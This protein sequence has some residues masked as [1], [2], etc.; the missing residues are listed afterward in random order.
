MYA[1]LHK[2]RKE[3]EKIS[4]YVLLVHKHRNN[5]IEPNNSRSSYVDWPLLKILETKQRYARCP[6]EKGCK[7]E[8]NTRELLSKAKAR[9]YRTG[10]GG[11]KCRDYDTTQTELRRPKAM[12]LTRQYRIDHRIGQKHH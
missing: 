5:K 2:Q 10:L 1:A 11:V 6:P 9:V 7:K 8:I 3:R 12:L 4:Q